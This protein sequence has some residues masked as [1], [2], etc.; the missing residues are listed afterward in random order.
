MQPAKYVLLLSMAFSSLTQAAIWPSNGHDYRVINVPNITRDAARTAAQSL[1][2]GWDLA[3]IEST[4]ENNFV[5]S[6]LN[7]GLPER[8]HFWIGGTDQATEGTWIW[9][10]GTPWSF[11]DWWAGAPDDP[12]GDEDFTAYDLRGGNWA[13]NDAPNDLTA[14][15]FPD[16]AQGYVAE[17]STTPSAAPTPASTPVPTMT[18]WGVIVLSVLVALGAVITL[19]RRRV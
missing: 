8:S 17:L 13:W 15:G 11:T 1:G 2:A 18:T 16:Y 4:G 19:R 5:K 12:T 6:L 7:N 10:D 14:A 9:V 3:T